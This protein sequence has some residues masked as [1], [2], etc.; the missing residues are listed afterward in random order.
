VECNDNPREIPRP[1]VKTRALRDD[2]VRNAR[3]KLSHYSTNKSVDIHLDRYIIEVFG[4][5]RSVSE[6]PSESRGFRFLPG[7]RWVETPK[8]N[9]HTGYVRGIPPFRK[10]RERMGHPAASVAVAQVAGVYGWGERLK[11]FRRGFARINTDKARHG[12]SRAFFS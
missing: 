11:P 1:A 2:A 6:A 12:E 8:S 4:R 10:K 9:S 7:Y 5:R 3:F